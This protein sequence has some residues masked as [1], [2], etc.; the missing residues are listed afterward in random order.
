MVVSKM[1]WIQPLVPQGWLTVPAET[2]FIPLPRVAVPSRM[3]GHFDVWLQAIKVYD[4]RIALD[5]FGGKSVQ[6]GR[7]TAITVH[8]GGYPVRR[9]RF[10]M[11]ERSTTVVGR[12]ERVIAASR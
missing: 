12:T 2:L 11:P 8:M 4:L 5:L 3:N 1:S 6:K 7:A 9:K 10:R